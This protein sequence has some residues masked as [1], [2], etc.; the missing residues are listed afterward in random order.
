MAPSNTTTQTTIIYVNSD[1]L[2]DGFLFGLRPPAANGAIL[3]L[4]EEEKSRWLADRPVPPA[5]WANKYPGGERV[6]RALEAVTK[7]I[8]QA[9]LSGNIVWLKGD[10]YETWDELN[11]VL[12]SKGL[13]EIYP[14]KDGQRY[15]ARYDRFEL[16]K[17]IT[18]QGLP[19]AVYSSFLTGKGEGD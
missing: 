19:Y 16:R 9:E 3:T 4:R 7:I 10:D 2:M 17:A 6:Q 15:R 5:Y 11:P 12:A 1:S 18:A 8:H 13:P 14:I